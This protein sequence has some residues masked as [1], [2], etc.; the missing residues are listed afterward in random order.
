MRYFIKV[1]VFLSS[2][3]L[4]F[5]LGNAIEEKPIVVIVCSYNNEKWIEKNLKSILTQKYSN[6]KV[7]YFDDCSTDST[8]R[9]AQEIVKLFGQSHRFTLIQNTER[10][11]A[12]ANYYRGIHDFCKDD[13]IVINVDGDDWL[14]HSHV[15]EKIN[16]VYSSSDI[17]LTHG[18]LIEY[19]T[20]SLVWSIPILQD[21]I[22]RNAF[23]EYRCPSHLRTFYAWLFKKIDIN[24]LLYNGFFFPMTWDQAIMF[25]MIEMA[26][27]R[28]A[29]IEEI[30]YVYNTSNRINDNKVNP[31][32]QRDLEC[33]IRS[34]P[35]YERLTHKPT[36]N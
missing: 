32:L 6:Y 25:P 13:E 12:L 23:R 26:G 18:T 24:D 4:S 3:K 31:Q 9:R 17:W 20:K 19:P 14:Y 29:F 5:L 30:L 35:R 1:L 27:D 7:I 36:N 15:F 28:H 11:G 22:A 8:A 34:K 33:Y 10:K 16:Q 2:F 21:I